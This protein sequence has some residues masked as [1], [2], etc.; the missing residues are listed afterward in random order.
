MHAL[1]VQPQ[2]AHSLDLRPIAPPG[3]Q[4]SKLLVR[5]LEIGICGTDSEIIAGQYGEA[6]A[7]CD[8]L[9]IGHECLGTVL[10]PVPGA[11]FDR[12]D[13]VVGFVR[14]PDP[15][16]CES[17]AAGEWDM[18]RNGG[19]RERGIKAADGY[20]AERFTLS[21]DFAIKLPADL[22]PVGVLTEPASIVAKA[23]EQ[24][25]RI[26]A[27]T[28][29]HPARALI[30]GAGP[31]G[32]LAALFGQQLGFEVHVFDRATTGP[33]PDLVRDLGAHY[34]TGSL[35]SLPLRPDIVIECTGAATVAVAAFQLLARNGILCLAGL[36]G[37]SHMVDLDL[38]AFGSRLVLENGLVFGS[39]NANRRHYEQ[40][41]NALAQAPRPWLARLISR[42]VAL[43]HWRD[44][45]SR[46]PNDIKVVIDFTIATSGAT[47]ESA[48]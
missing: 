21:P 7:G 9:V 23:W 12:G 44:A 20:A 18:C 17:C 8:H 5:C 36:S 25:Q 19:Y 13:L 24:I 45:F 3:R 30:T 38:S 2:K 39:V 34:H 4:P 47:T 40:A 46:K 16:P 27:R 15:A 28:A 37:G 6:P 10:Q 14:R 48:P 26:G 41:V 35:A 32:L 29:W 42:R 33:K 31:I 22:R 11:A 43:P 1:T